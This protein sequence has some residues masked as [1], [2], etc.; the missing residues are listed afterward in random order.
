MNHEIPRGPDILAGR[1]HIYGIHPCFCQPAIYPLFPVRNGILIQNEL[2]SQSRARL[3]SDLGKCLQRPWRMDERRRA[4]KR[5]VKL[6]DL[7]AG[8]GPDVGEFECG[9]DSEV[10]ARTRRLGE[11]EF[12]IL[13]GCVG[14]AEPT[15]TC[16]L[17]GIS[18][19][20][21]REGGQYPK[22]KRGEILQCK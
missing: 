4:R 22:G 9:G 20:K 8:N 3:Q 13:E 5:Y 17:G 7:R 18:R 2:D 16:Q 19:V 21:P 15:K 12:G 6:Y 14:K 11:R 1:G 10:R